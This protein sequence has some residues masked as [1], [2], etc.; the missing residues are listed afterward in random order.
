MSVSLS[1][2]ARAR[3][4][5]VDPPTTTAPNTA[6]ECSNWIVAEN[7]STCEEIAEYNWITV[8]Q[9]KRWG[10]PEEEEPKTT[11]TIAAGPTTTSTVSNGIITPT[12]TQEGIIKDYNKFH[13]VSTGQGCA[14]VQSLYG[15]SWADFYRWNPAVG[16]NCETL[17]A[18][19]NV[20]VGVI[21][22]ASVST[23]V[24]ATATTTAGNGIATPS[25]TQ[26]GMVG[27]CNKFH[28]VSG[29]QDCPAIQYLYGITFDQLLRWNP[30]IGASCQGMWANTYLCVSTT[31]DQT[32]LITSTKTTVITT[33]KP[34]TTAGNGI[35]TPQPIQTGIPTN[36]DKFHTVVAGDE[37][38]AIA[39]KYSVSLSQFYAW[40]PAIGTGCST[41]WAGYNVCVH[42]VGAT[43]I[44][45]TASPTST[46]NGIA[47][48]TPTQPVASGDTC[49]VIASKYGT[50]S[51]KIHSWNT[52]INSA[53]NNIWLGYY[54][55]VG[56]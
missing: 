28:F 21:G 35:S 53:C 26:A 14:T 9:L 10:A 39:N 40:N 56:V 41:L 1:L 24:P 15:L 45:T 29:G 5:L 32:T 27:N 34:T 37:C 7:S 17:W 25:P 47:T 12:P 36:C 54:V 31:T 52:Q 50:T 48:P 2:A 49:D 33:S 46:G 30:A 13:F 4:Y 18:N 11:T 6:E 38:Q 16:A 22:G 43:T 55:C 23:S 8:T 51:T 3:A 19:T 44:K 42:T 20:C